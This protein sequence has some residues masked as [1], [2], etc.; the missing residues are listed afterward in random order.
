[1]AD[2]TFTLDELKEFFA[3][4]GDASLGRLINELTNAGSGTITLT[5][6][7]KKLGDQF[8]STLQ[9]ASDFSDVLDKIYK[10]SS[11]SW[12]RMTQGIN[13]YIERQ[14]MTSHGAAVFGTEVALA[15]ERLLGIIPKGISGLGE[16]G[17]SGEAAGIQITKSFNNLEPMFEKFAPGIGRVVGRMAESADRA[18][19]LENSII[20][21]AAAQGNLGSILEDN[22]N[23]FN[24]LNQR[25]MEFNIMTIESARATGQTVDSMANLADKMSAIP[26]VFEDS[27]EVAG[28]YRNQLVVAAT[29]A[30]AFGQDQSNVASTLVK[31]YETVGLS[32]DTAYESLSNIYDKAG[33]SK[34]R[35]ETFTGTVLDMAASFKMLGDNTDAATNI[36]KSFDDAFKG[37]DISPEAM[38]SVISSLG[39]GVKSMERGTQAFISAQTGGPGGLAGAFQMEFALQTGRLDEVLSKTLDAMEGQ[40]GGRVLTLE[41]VNENQALA[42]EFYKQVRYLTDVAKIA[43][44]DREAYRILEAMKSGVTDSIESGLGETGQQELETIMD[45]GVS[46]Q[47]RTTSV[48]VNMNNTL[49]AMKL[50][51]DNIYADANTRLTQNLEAPDRMREAA[52]RTART[53][54]I[55]TRK[56]AIEGETRRGFIEGE[57]D[58]FGDLLIGNFSKFLEVSNEG[59]TGEKDRGEE[60]RKALSTFGDKVEKEGFTPEAVTSLLGT[61]KEGVMPGEM[62]RTP[63]IGAL[64]EPVGAR[65]VPGELGATPETAPITETP[66]LPPP[67]PA[68]LLPAEGAA[69][70]VPVPPPPEVNIES[71]PALNFEGGEIGLNLESREA[72]G[73]AQDMRF[74]ERP[75]PV[76][77]AVMPEIAGEGAETLPLEDN[78]GNLTSVFESLKGELKP[79]TVDV[80]V[81]FESMPE[82][83]VSLDKPNTLAHIDMVVKRAGAENEKREITRANI[84]RG[85]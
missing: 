84:G 80:N 65:I 30:R 67:I 58:R 70:G 81:G 50:T 17:S 31:L 10:I 34:L 5:E 3:S 24:D 43:G 40:F 18:Y 25:Q 72:L 28:N 57:L 44:D 68:P 63:P 39:E 51:Q 55:E 76:T 79:L 4:T 54:V 61:V 26:G 71:V 37:S 32:G 83:M 78:L 62:E 23:R 2:K 16:L 9:Y 6:L 73:A 48:L 33:D 49:T 22:G 13:E 60:I 12:E 74:L 69:P 85:A 42:G 77:P 1:M 29:V 66:A 19:T 8:V 21:M 53:G 20:R 27:V 11:N 82:I 45:R 38:K 52:E 59:Q 75:S 56:E 46:E 47:E 41:D 14:D 64:G 35:F 15:G 7:T 36:V